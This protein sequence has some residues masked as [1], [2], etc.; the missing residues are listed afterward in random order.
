MTCEANIQ[1]VLQPDRCFKEMSDPVLPRQ[2]HVSQ[3]LRHGNCEQHYFE[4]T[5]D[6]YRV[7]CSEE[8]NASLLALNER[9]DQQAC[10]VLSNVETVLLSAANGLD[11]YLNDEVMVLKRVW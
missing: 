9:F 3:R 10:S 2:S 6:L 8:I 1:T 5:K 7:Q 11:F 4:P